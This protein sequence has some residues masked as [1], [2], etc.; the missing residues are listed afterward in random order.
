VPDCEGRLL[1]AL[2]KN[3]FFFWAVIGASVVHLAGPG[4]NV[5][6]VALL[7]RWLTRGRL[8]YSFTGTS[9]DEQ[10]SRSDAAGYAKS[11]RLV[12]SV[13]DV[14]E[15]LNRQVLN[16]SW[17]R[18]ERLLVAPCSFSDPSVFRPQSKS[19]A[20]V[21][22]GHFLR[23]KGVADL[24][25]IIESGVG[26]G[27]EFYVYG[28]SGGDD[29]GVRFKGWLVEF[30]KYNPWVKLCYSS[31]M[32][33]AYSRARYM[34]SLQSISNYPSQSVLEALLSGCH[35][36]MSDSGDSR[37]FG[38]HGCITYL[39]RDDISRFWD[40]LDSYDARWNPSMPLAARNYVLQSHS[41]QRYV[42]HLETLWACV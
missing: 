25:N 29:E 8:L 36:F 34:V 38:D 37:D 10:L 20:V 39:G 14:T 41:V 27:Y 11:V 30:C 4:F 42:R 16:D 23:Q 35:V 32:A 2:V 26:R 6:P 19:R 33:E 15:I 17:L 21:F 1:D 13:A 7:W 40:L 28:D 3:V 24:R 5:Y 9:L 18:P 12:Q 22:S 31:N